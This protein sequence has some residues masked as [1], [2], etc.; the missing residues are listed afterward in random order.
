MKLFIEI[1]DGLFNEVRRLTKAK[2]KRD[3]VIIPMREYVSLRK[4]RDLADMI[5][6]YDLGMTLSDLKKSRK[7]W[8]K[9]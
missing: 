3:A 7:Q 9:S 1:D 8:K 6:S 5:G 2:K 4:R